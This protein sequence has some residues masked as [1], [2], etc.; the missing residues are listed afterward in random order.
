MSVASDLF[1]REVLMR[2]WPLVFEEMPT[3][4]E[5]QIV[6]A[7][8]KGEGGYGL[9]TYRLL[10]VEPG[11]GY[12]SVIGESQQT[13][14]WGASQHGSPVNGACG[15][16]AFMA[17]D[18]SPNRVTE[19]NPKGYYYACF[20]RFA[21]PDLGCEAYLKILL[22]GSKAHPRQAVREAAFTGSADEVA[23]AMYES[24]YFEGFGATPEDRIRHYADAIEKNAA[25]IAKN[26][27]EPMMVVR[28]ERS[29]LSRGIGF[30]ELLV[31]GGGL[32]ALWRG[33]SS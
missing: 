9:A 27:G 31:L 22:S 3:P 28:G 14:N 16:D 13:N 20:R 33:L 11:P 4:V 6:Q 1:G 7:V 32:Y 23:R 30:G 25:T 18:S 26:L 17:T 21:T 29:V 24:H 12:G 8:S 19:D 15:P 5:L 10:Q 2:V